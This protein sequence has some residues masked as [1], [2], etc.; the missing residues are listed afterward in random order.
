MQQ[1]ISYD[2]V[3]FVAKCISCWELKTGNGVSLIHSYFY[4]T[5]S[6]RVLVGTGRACYETLRPLAYSLLAELIHHVRLDLSLPQVRSEPSASLLQI[7]S[8]DPTM[9]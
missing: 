8:K 1:T 6:C 2:C 7:I 5:L 3:H 9:L 4:S